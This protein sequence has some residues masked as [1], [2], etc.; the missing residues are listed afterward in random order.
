MVSLMTI[1]RGL[2]LLVFVVLV[3]CGGSPS[4][5]PKKP[6]ATPAPKVIIEQEKEGK[7]RPLPPEVKIK[8]RRDGKDNYSWELNGSDADQI[9]KVN[10][11]LKKQL[12]GDSSR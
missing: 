8:L 12:T 9:L 4:S 10:E 3:S 6:E 2:I 1:R 7:T 5:S 11:K